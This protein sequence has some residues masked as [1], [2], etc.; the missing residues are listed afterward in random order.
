VAGSVDTTMPPPHSERLAQALPR[1]RYVSL[2]EVGHGV[3]VER[4]HD[5]AAVA[6]EFLDGVG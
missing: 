3:P 5:L 4:P 1:G 2:A 6:G